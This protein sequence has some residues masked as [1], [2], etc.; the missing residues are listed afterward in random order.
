MCRAG[1]CLDRHES[2]VAS[3]ISVGR[4]GVEQYGASQ[5]TLYHY[6]GLGP[7]GAGACDATTTREAYEWFAATGVQ[8]VNESFYCFH[9]LLTGS[10]EHAAQE[11]GFIQDYYAR[12]YDIVVVRAAGNFAQE[13][14][15][16]NPPAF[17][18][19]CPHT[20]NATCVGG[21]DHNGAV[22]CVS[23]HQN[24]ANVDREEP[25]VL[26]LA[27]ASLS[28]S[29][30]TDPIV[31]VDVAL[32]TPSG[33]S[34]M[35]TKSVGGTSFAAPQVT[36][37]ATLIRE[38]C[39]FG[40]P[41]TRAFIRN[42]GRVWTPELTR[43]STP[44]PGRDRR[45]GAGSPDAWG[46]PLDCGGGGDLMLD[47]TQTDP[48][49]FEADCENCSEELARGG[50]L[51]FRNAS[52][53]RFGASGAHYKEL[54]VLEPNATR[55][56]VTF[57]WDACATASTMSAPAPVSTDFDL[58]LVDTQQA[59]V[60]YGSLSNDDN[61]EGFDVDLTQFGTSQYAVWLSWPESAVP[62]DGAGTEHTGFALHQEY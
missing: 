3:V 15:E 58:W 36:Q 50:G 33:A 61:N 59:R 57:S 28:C 53:T 23:Q 8:V 40:A 55:V 62:C 24:P 29:D 48:P 11:D 43:Y 20:L 5:A 32:I 6:N 45:D 21:I 7:N 41:A 14:A 1:R 9:P 10:L 38:R 47:L 39:G 31:G 19:A 27:G 17:A 16:A 56:R 13:A 44:G 22:S 26:S 30:T 34:T 35:W 54:A 42:A 37:L 49:P 51:R 60:I 52:Q 46:F 25:D 4:S 2:Q 12:T 18:P